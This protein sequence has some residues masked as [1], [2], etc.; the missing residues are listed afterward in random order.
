MELDKRIKEGKRPLTCFDIKEAE[1][2][3]G[4]HGYFAHAM[5]VFENLDCC[6]FSR[7]LGFDT[8]DKS[9][10]FAVANASRDYEF[11]I[12]EEWTKE[13]E[14]KYRPYSLTEWIN[15]HEIGDVIHYRSKSEKIEAHVMYMGTYHHKNKG[16]IVLGVA[17][18]TLDCLFDDCE[19]E[20]NGEWQPFGIEVK[21]NEE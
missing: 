20:V 12:P 14:K 6:Y 19:I 11:F 9:I 8:C 17:S 7:L 3:R 15:Q 4:K 18:Y 2:F 16:T 13:P 10:P 21:E 5:E 1:Q